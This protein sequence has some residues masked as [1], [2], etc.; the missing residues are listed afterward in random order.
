[1]GAPSAPPEERDETKELRDWFRDKQAP[2]M[3]SLL[4]QKETLGM[5][6]FG[7][8]RLIEMN[9]VKQIGQGENPLIHSGFFALKIMKKSEILRLKQTQH[10]HD[11]R[12][13]LCK[14]KNPFIV[15]LYHTYSDERN[16][17]MVMEFISGGEIGSKLKQAEVFSNERARFYIAQLVM[18]LQYLHT[19]HT[20]Y[21]GV[22]TDNVL[23]EKDGYIKLV[24]FGFAKYLPPKEDEDN[25]TYTL[26]GTP[27][28]LAPEI[29]NAK[30]HGKGADWWAMGILVYE[31]LAGYPPFYAPEPFEIYQK[32][33]K[34]EYRTPNQFSEQ[35]TS[36]IKRLLHQDQ[37]KRLGC[38]AGGAEEIKKQK[39]FRGLDWAAL[40]N[41]QLKAPED[42]APEFDENNP[43]ANFDS[44]EDSN[45]ESGPL[46]STE[47]AEKFKFWCALP[48]Q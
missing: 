28:Y 3:S 13:L 31:M 33:L 34:G 9:E 19:E 40:Y 47:D 25:K 5:G 35:A 23:L 7:R 21:R 22:G 32:V 10:V 14:L 20:I 30:G 15:T 44:Y 36:L 48:T 45:E 27:E 16:A 4:Q 29:V 38:S 46:L 8:V 2:A 41:K 1:M 37:V 24:D 39:W 26:C 18:C 11:E 6:H 12:K 17:F 43:A 42:S